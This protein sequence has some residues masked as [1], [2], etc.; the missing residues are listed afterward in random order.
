MRLSLFSLIALAT[1]ACHDDKP[2]ETPHPV[3]GDCVIDRTQV[4]LECVKTA[5][6]SAAADECIAKAKAAKECT[7]GGS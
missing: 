7:D 6:T 5:P 2:I 4:Q 1:A 3:E